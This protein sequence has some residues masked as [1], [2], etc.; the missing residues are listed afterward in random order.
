MSTRRAR[1][2]RLI[3]LI[4]G[5]RHVLIPL[6]LSPD[7]DSVGS[8][9]AMASACRHLGSTATVVSSDPPP[10][11]YRYLHGWEEIRRPDDVG[12]DYDMLMLLDCSSFSR[13]GRVRDLFPAER[14]PL[15]VTI[16]HHRT[17]TLVGEF[18]WIDPDAAATAEMIFDWMVRSR[19]PIDRRVAASLYTGIAT[20]TG[21][22]CFSNTT[23]S[24]LARASALVRRGARPNQVHRWVNEDRPVRAVGILGRAL[25]K[26]Q[27]DMGGAL[28][29]TVVTADDL[30][31][32]GAV[33]D[34]TEGVIN[35]LRSVSGTELCIIFVETGPGHV[36]VSFRSRERVD[37]SE[38]A[39]SFGGGG[40]A[41]AA[42]T[43][44]KG[45][46]NRVVDEVLSASKRVLRD[47]G[48]AGD[49]CA[50]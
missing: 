43:K 41:R 45:E 3:E 34:D 2:A 31:D 27:T 7:G 33:A 36:K 5:A 48:E 17:G 26:M 4:R 24:T 14:V 50:E 16:D 8:C 49:R 1:D 15:T 46:T 30:R 37:V 12:S 11:L 32:K 25:D 19:I 47:L 38:V 28:A 40:H 9:L 29:W 42:G 20:D 6:H 44:I 39:A 23:A 10:R 13:I 22:F 21:F 18:R 35:H